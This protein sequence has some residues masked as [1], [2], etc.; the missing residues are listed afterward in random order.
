MN[1]L[2]REQKGFH[3]K[4]RKKDILAHPLRIREKGECEMGALTTMNDTFRFFQKRYTDIAMPAVEGYLIMMV[5]QFAVIPII[6]LMVF[7]SSITMVFDEMVGAI[8]MVFMF[9]LIYVFMLGIAAFAMG[10]MYGGMVKTIDDIRN[11]RKVKFGDTFKYGWKHK[12]ELFRIQILNTI[13]FMLITVFIYGGVIGLGMLILYQNPVA[14]IIFMFMMM[15]IVSFGIYTLLPLQYLPF[16]VR[17]KKGIYGTANVGEGWKEFFTEFSTYGGIGFMFMLLLIIVMFIP[18]VGIIAA[19]ALHPAFISALLI[20]Y[21]E[22]YQIPVVPEI[23]KFY[24]ASQNLQT[25]PQYGGY[26]PQPPQ[27]E[28]P[29][30][31]QQYDTTYQTGPWH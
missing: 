4:H 20:H 27:Q 12:W 31:P 21:D 14:G 9:I 29:Q 18:F 22:K 5:T 19:L 6:F 2:P 30:N 1:I 8:V 16:V 3:S 11:H 15:F 13:L 26:P 28:Y 7:L 24:E 23:P 25:P 10:I 17:Y